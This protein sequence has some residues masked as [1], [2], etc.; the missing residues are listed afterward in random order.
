MYR[1]TGKTLASR[2]APRLE[3]T[4]QGHLVRRQTRVCCPPAAAALGRG[5]RPQ[6]ALQRPP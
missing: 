4:R 6:V 5:R 1:S 3:E 2:T